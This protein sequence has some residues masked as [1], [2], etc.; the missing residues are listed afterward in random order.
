MHNWRRNMGLTIS[1]INSK[2]VCITVTLYWTKFRS[3]M[4]LHQFDIF[5][6]TETNIDCSHRIYRKTNGLRTWTMT[7][8][9]NTLYLIYILNWINLIAIQIILSISSSY[10]LLNN[11]LRN[12]DLF[13]LL[14]RRDIIKTSCFFLEIK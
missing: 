2:C 3:D 10:L 1:C 4:I 9:P 5:A 12:S 7:V 6:C 13:F 8:E 14:L 11:V